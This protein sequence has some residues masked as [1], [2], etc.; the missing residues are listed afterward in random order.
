MAYQSTHSLNPDE[1]TLKKRTRKA[2]QSIE[3]RVRVGY[4]TGF[5]R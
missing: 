3:R 1:E 2:M 4:G 5:V